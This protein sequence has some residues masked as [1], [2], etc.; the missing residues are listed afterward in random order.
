MLKFVKKSVEQM[1]GVF[2]ALIGN[3]KTYAGWVSTIFQDISH[4]FPVKVL[5]YFPQ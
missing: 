3:P 1:Y 2:N 4:K 5:L